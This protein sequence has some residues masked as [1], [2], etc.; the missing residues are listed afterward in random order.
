MNAND[1]MNAND[2]IADELRRQ[3]PGL[4]HEPTPEEEARMLAER[5][6]QARVR[7]TEEARQR[8]QTHASWGI[9]LKDIE[10]IGTGHLRETAAT[11]ILAA[12][13]EDRTT[14]LLVLSGPVGCGKTTAA[15]QWLCR[16][17]EAPSWLETQPPLFLPVAQF[18]RT[19][20]YSAQA[21][22]RMERARALVLDDLGAE[23]LDDKGA[24]VALLDS[25]IDARYRDLRPTVITTNLH[26]SQFAARYGE[27]TVDRIRERGRFVELAGES[28][29]R[30]G[31][32]SHGLAS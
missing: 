14:E 8:R 22:S 3:Y 17:R 32:S 28:Q 13:A 18:E 19:S 30:K 9:P 7:A 31:G 20:R 12:F 5:E 21:M 10:A 4:F 16:A 26:A 2:E 15:A 1:V 29:R 27:R 6:R 24:F 23:Y 11:R 25:L